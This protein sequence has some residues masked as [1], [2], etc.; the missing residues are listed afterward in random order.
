LVANDG[1]RRNAVTREETSLPRLENDRKRLIIP[2]RDRRW[3]EKAGNASLLR[4]RLNA[5]QTPQ[6][7]PENVPRGT[8]TVRTAEKHVP[9][10]TFCVDAAKHRGV[11]LL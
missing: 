7:Q 5:V 6:V 4:I 10:G 8:S 9:R 3:E 1:N 2:F 11:N